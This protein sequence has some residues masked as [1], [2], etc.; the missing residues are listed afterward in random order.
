MSLQP[1]K[2]DRRKYMINCFHGVA[3]NRPHR[4]FRNFKKGNYFRIVRDVVKSEF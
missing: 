1:L 2:S 4:D 3:D